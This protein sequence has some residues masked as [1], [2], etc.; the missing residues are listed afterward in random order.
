MNTL[1]PEFR[2]K[3]EQITQLSRKV[4]SD[5]TQKIFDMI[6]DHVSEIAELYE[7]DDDHWAIETADL[8]VLCYELLMMENKN[9]DEIF[10]TCLPRFDKKLN[11]LALEMNIT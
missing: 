2:E 3:I 4:N 10:T 6:F 7:S 5:D 11:Q 9:I 8:I 1:Q